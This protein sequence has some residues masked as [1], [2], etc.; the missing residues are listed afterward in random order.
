MISD[1]ITK[2][3]GYLT[4]FFVSLLWN[5]SITIAFILIAH[6][7]SCL[8]SIPIFTYSPFYSSL[9]RLIPIYYVGLLVVGF[10]IALA[11][12]IE[13]VGSLCRSYLLYGVSFDL[14]DWG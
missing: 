8:S 12:K 11:T 13:I 7:P 10:V 3:L 4:E 6:A 9:L 1:T 2:V 14:L 5:I